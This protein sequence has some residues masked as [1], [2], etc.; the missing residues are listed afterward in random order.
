MPLTN[1]SLS[2]F[3]REN[4]FRKHQQANVTR[5]RPIMETVASEFRPRAIKQLDS[6]A[7]DD[8]KLFHGW[9]G[10][11]GGEITY[12]GDH[13]GTS[14]LPSAMMLLAFAGLMWRTWRMV[15]P[16]SAAV[17]ARAVES[18]SARPRKKR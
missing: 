8:P 16:I 9:Y 13:F 5:W 1:E 7:S 6:M 14:D 4:W 2:A 18:K 15:P 3:G 11:H 10:R 17:P 12:L